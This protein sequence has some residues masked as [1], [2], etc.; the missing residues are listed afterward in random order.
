MRGGLL[1]LLCGGTQT[2]TIPARLRAAY[3]Y[4]AAPPIRNPR[5][6]FRTTLPLGKTPR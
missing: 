3:R 6:G 5:G 2:V 4:S 1:H